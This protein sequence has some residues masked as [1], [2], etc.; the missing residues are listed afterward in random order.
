M[1]IK[2]GE[3]GAIIGVDGFS[4]HDFVNYHETIGGPR[5]ST[6]HR[7]EGFVPKSKK[8]GPILA[9]KVYISSFA[10]PVSIDNITLDT[11]ERVGRARPKTLDEFVRTL[12][13]AD[14]AALKPLTD[15]IGRFLAMDIEQSMAV[16]IRVFKLV[17]APIGI[18]MATAVIERMRKE[19]EAKK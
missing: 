7:I 9:M 8:G 15:C 1:E 10:H 5:T 19:Y 2:R 11:E 3:S 14:V 18:T 16:A 13:S 4:M 17:S 6:G 12:N